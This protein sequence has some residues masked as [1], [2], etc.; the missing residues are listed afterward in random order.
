MA[1][2]VAMYP[3]PRCPVC[4]KIGTVEIPVEKLSQVK[5]WQVRKHVRIQELL[6]ELSADDREMLMT[7]LHPM[8]WK[9]IMGE[10]S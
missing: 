9:E 5:Q 1:K 10:E 6:P 3:T 8:C 7:G 2:A 4:G